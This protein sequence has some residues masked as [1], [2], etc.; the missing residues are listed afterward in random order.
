MFKTQVLRIPKLRKALK[1]PSSLT[2]ADVWHFTNTVAANC[3]QTYIH[4]TIDS[5][6]HHRRVIHFNEVTNVQ[7]ISV[8]KATTAAIGLYEHAVDPALISEE[9]AEIQNNSW[10]AYHWGQQI[11]SSYFSHITCHMLRHLDFFPFTKLCLRYPIVTYNLQTIKYL[12][13]SIF[14]FLLSSHPISHI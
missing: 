7:V 1:R 2:S 8:S 13:L 11:V 9:A 6:N 5:L 12:H 4:Q 3:E 14:S 10:N